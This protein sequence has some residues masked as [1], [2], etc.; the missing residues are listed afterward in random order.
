M[1]GESQGNQNG[2]YL[3]GDAIDC[4]GGRR[5][6]VAEWRQRIV[7]RFNL[8]A[9]AMREYLNAIGRSI[10]ATLEMGERVP[11][12]GRDG[13]RFHGYFEYGNWIAKYKML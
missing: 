9:M 13:K 7:A 6:V 10:P 3:D 2:L 4:A 1:D 11:K 5:L 12:K 8:Y